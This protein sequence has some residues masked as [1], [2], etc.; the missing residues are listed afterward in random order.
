MG[1]VVTALN[2]PVQQ[3]DELGLFGHNV[4]RQLTGELAVHDLQA[5]GQAKIDARGSHDFVGDLVE[6]ATH[7]ADLPALAVRRAHKL[8]RAGGKRHALKGALE[9]TLVQAGKQ[10]HALLERLL[11]V[12]FAAHGTLSDLRHLLAYAGLLAQQVDDL[13]VDECGVDIHNDEACSHGGPFRVQLYW[14]TLSHV[15]RL[16]DGQ[17]ASIVSSPSSLWAR[18]TFSR[19]IDTGAIR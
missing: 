13:L 12:Q 16:G 7:D 14:G 6:A 8:Q 15:A 11:K 10:P 2:C 19:H 18:V 17:A 3:L 1:H 9:H 5:V 4:C